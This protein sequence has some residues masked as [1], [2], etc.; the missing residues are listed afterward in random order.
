M[1]IGSAVRIL[2]TV[3]VADGASVTTVVVDVTDPEGT[4]LVDAQSMTEETANT[5]YSYVFQTSAGNA[6]GEYLATCTAVSGAYTGISRV[7]FKMHD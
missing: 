5:L 6:E 1:H 4:K 2:D 7:S 3:V